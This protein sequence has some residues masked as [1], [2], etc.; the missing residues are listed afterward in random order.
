MQ[1]Q[2]NFFSDKHY[3]INEQQ[4]NTCTHL[5]LKKSYYYSYKGQRDKESRGAGSGP[6]LPTLPKFRKSAKME[7]LYK[8]LHKVVRRWMTS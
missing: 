5:K 6:M 7:L 2:V 8:V 4:E 1:P 3:Q